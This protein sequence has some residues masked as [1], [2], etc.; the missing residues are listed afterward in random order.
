MALVV[1][2]CGISWCILC[3]C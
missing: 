3:R 1:V 2:T